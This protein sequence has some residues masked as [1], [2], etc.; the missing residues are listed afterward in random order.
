M[1]IRKNIEEIFCDFKDYSKLS[2]T[3]SGNEYIELLLSDVIIG[4]LKVWTDTGNGN[5]EYVIINNEVIYLN[6]IKI[7]NYGKH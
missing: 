4:N 5:M 2:I 6:T 1:K 7:N 3:D